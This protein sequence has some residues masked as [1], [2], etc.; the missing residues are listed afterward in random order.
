MH[1]CTSYI[2]HRWPWSI[3]SMSSSH[4]FLFHRRGRAVD[5]CPTTWYAV[6]YLAVHTLLRRRKI[7]TQGA[8]SRSQLYRFFPIW[9]HH[10]YVMSLIVAV[11]KTRLIEN[12]R[13]PRNRFL[14][15]V[16]NHRLN[17]DRKWRPALLP[18]ILIDFYW[19]NFGMHIRRR[20]KL[21]PLG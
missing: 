3:N 10:L 2:L 16:S 13:P 20:A 21:F 15:P 12:A 4:R 19:P 14:S 11:A 18:S 5:C 1:T 6:P 9:I 7:L 17:L 8:I